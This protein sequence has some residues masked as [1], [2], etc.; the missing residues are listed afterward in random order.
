[1]ILKSAGWSVVD[2]WSRKMVMNS[3][4][5]RLTSTGTNAD[6]GVAQDTVRHEETECQ[7]GVKGSVVVT[8]IAPDELRLSLERTQ[9]AGP[10][11]ES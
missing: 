8:Y 10:C 9:I 1:M 5:N 11:P 6:D 7:T 3:C 4:L 2:S